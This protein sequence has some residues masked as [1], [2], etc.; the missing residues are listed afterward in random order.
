MANLDSPLQTEIKQGNIEKIIDLLN[1]GASPN[2][3][4]FVCECK[5]K[6]QDTKYFDIFKLLVERGADVYKDI[7][8]C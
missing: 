3:L 1:Q 8:F 7:S 5:F 4:E 6:H 2:Q